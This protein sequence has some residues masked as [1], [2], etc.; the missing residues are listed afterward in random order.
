M[1]KRTWAPGLV[2]SLL[3]L[4]CVEGSSGS[5]TTGETTTRGQEG[6]GEASG[7]PTTGGADASSTGTTAELLGSSGGTAVGTTL[8]ES[9]S[10]DACEFICETTTGEPRVP[11]CDLFMQDCPEGEK[12]TS[13]GLGEGA[14][15]SGHRCVPVTGTGQPGEPCMVMGSGISG[16]DDC[17]KGM[18]CWY[19]DEQLHGACIE[20]CGGSVDMPVCQSDVSCSIAAEA[21]VAI[22]IP[23]CHPLVQDCP[24]V[25]MCVPLVEG[26]SCVIDASGEEGQAFDACASANV[27]DEGLVCWPAGSALECDQDA[28]GCCL[29]MCDLADPEVV[30]PGAGQSCVSIYEEGMAPPESAKVGVCAVPG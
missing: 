15:L 11:D 25:L 24:G 27:C 16:F 13:Y 3:L 30:C 17:A 7:V 9:S 21:I 6:S 19:I 4:A 29:P 22:C 18:M 14:N 26:F 20:I 12:C 2:G 8:M 1:M 28:T 5:D 10:G 23:N